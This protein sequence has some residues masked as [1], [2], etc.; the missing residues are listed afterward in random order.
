LFLVDLD[1]TFRV[2]RHRAKRTR[3]AG[4]GYGDGRP[5]CDAVTFWLPP[6]NQ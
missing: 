4:R 2:Q 6:T 1:G 3:V 5:M